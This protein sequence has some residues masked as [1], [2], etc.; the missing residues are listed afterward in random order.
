VK[1]L[2][3]RYVPGGADFAREVVLPAS[4][5]ISTR[6]NREAVAVED[7]VGVTLLDEAAPNAASVALVPEARRLLEVILAGVTSRERAA[8]VL[9]VLGELAGEGTQPADNVNREE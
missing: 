1:R 7:L 6:Y 5:V 8:V 9:A 2:V 3:L 4:A